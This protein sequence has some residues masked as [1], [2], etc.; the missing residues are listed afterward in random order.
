MHAIPKS[1]RD[2]PT[3]VQAATLLLISVL[4]A[5]GLSRF[6]PRCHD[7]QELSE[8]RTFG[9]S[10]T[11]ETSLPNIRVAYS[12]GQHGQPSATVMIDRDHW[13]TQVENIASQFHGGEWIVVECG[14]ATCE[15]GWDLA[16][17]L[18][19]YGFPRVATLRFEG[20]P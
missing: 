20:R 19:R 8:I 3:F 15:E 10:D 7:V 4:G 14:S 1:A 9:A 6:H 12:S 2:F 18:R 11:S 13:D 17:K 5:V 16:K